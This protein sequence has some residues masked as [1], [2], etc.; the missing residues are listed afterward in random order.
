MKFTH[1]WFIIITIFGQSCFSQTI[2]WKQANNWQLYNIRSKA[3]FNY[4][5]DTLTNF[6][7]ITLDSSIMSEFLNNVTL[8]SNNRPVLW[9]GL[10][11][12]S[13]EMPDKKK[14]K[15][16]FSNFGGFFWDDNTQR[17]FELADTLKT[18]WHT[19]LHESAKKVFHQP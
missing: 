16:I 9:Q 13:C 12:A 19:Y 1:Y 5:L 3:G 4:P 18:R 15:I 2:N 14:R 6:K 17:H 8:V 11:V 7:H 10:Y